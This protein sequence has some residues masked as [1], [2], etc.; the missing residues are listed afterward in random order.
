V[1][2]TGKSVGVREFVVVVGYLGERLKATLTNHADLGV[3]I[4]FVENPDWQKGN[5]IS[6]LKA[7][8]VLND[9][10]FLLMAD[11]VFDARIL[12]AL[13]DHRPNTP[14]VL[15]VDR[16][17]P[18]EGDTRVLTIDG[19]IVDIG[20]DVDN[21]NCLDT[22]IFLCSPKVFS[23]I[24]K[25]VDK[26]KTELSD[27]IAEAARSQDAETLDISL[28]DKYLPGMRK[29]SNPFWID[30]DNREDL[31]KA[32]K[33]LIGTA[34]K[35]R[36]D[37]LA[38]Y[39][40]R[41]IENFL[42][43]RLAKKKITA[44]HITVLTNVLAYGATL[45][46]F[47]GYLLFGSFLTFVVSILDGVDGK[48]SRVKLSSSSLG[49]MEHAFDF[50]FEHSWYIALSLYVSRAYGVSAILMGALVVLFDGFAHYCE[51]AFG[52]TI[53]ERPLV[54]YGPVEQLFRRF[55]GRR[56]TYILLMLLGVLLEVPFWSLVGICAWSF[57]SAV[58]Y[59]SRA[60]KHL[61]ARDRIRER[62]VSTDIEVT[63]ERLARQAAPESDRP[64]V[65]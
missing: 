49:K 34:S 24:E 22:G 11:H 15:A 46:I 62:H 52:K 5:G 1:I 60:F 21:G 47:K 53:K 7:K 65:V 26:G 27:G 13:I 55:D 45:A 54:D 56:N 37:I 51:D 64:T 32:E 3:T 9:D 40:N 25:A 6:V 57:V 8:Q 48:L 10:F 63:D 59:G 35:G 58:F 23:Y 12:Q 17:P 42:V 50:L 19:S 33:L 2:L 41:P 44:N 29:E 31:A 20:K 16:R 30:I 39:V 14:V 36:N 61:R 38:S 28:I 4:S 18:N 43:K